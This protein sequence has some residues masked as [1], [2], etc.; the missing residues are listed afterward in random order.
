MQVVILCYRSALLD[1][2]YQRGE[3]GGGGITRWLELLILRKH[4]AQPSIGLM[5]SMCCQENVI[6]AVIPC[7]WFAIS[8]SCVEVHCPGRVFVTGF[9]GTFIFCRLPSQKL[10]E[11]G[12]T[13]THYKGMY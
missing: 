2:T 4:G 6:Q 12:N 1:C 9:I 7:A 13:N 10:P 11:N 5:K 8:S 3:G